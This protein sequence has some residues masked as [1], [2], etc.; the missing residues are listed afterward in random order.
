M[1]FL[2]LERS[3]TTSNEQFHCWRRVGVTDLLLLFGFVA[4]NH[5]VRRKSLGPRRFTEY[6]IPALNRRGFHDNLKKEV[7]L[8]FL[9]HRRIVDHDMNKSI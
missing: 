8:C 6:K 2:L 4:Q 3:R 7:Q 9:N 1:G 5:I